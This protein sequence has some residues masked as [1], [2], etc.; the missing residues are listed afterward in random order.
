MQPKKSYWQTFTTPQ[1]VQIIT[2]LEGCKASGKTAMI[3]SDTGTCKTYSVDK[4]CAK[5]PENTYRI[6]ISDVYKLKDLIDEI[7]DLVGVSREYGRYAISNKRTLD[8]IV[9]RLKAVQKAGGNPIVII[10]EGENMTVSLLKTIKALYDLLKDHCA[11]V[12]IGTPRLV[13]RMLNRS[14]TG[15]IGKNRNALPELYRRFKAYHKTITP[16]NK[17]RD[18]KPFFDKYVADKGLRKLLCT[19]C[20][21]YGEL[22]DYLEPA[23]REA[24]E[25]GTALTEDTFRIMYNLPKY[26]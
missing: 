24:D 13:N 26:N 22:N 16:V 2:T 4:F 5:H 8:R 18:F 9:A 7:A 15:G 6:T 14:D 3:I 23:L 19:L 25:K 10:D 21:N 17:E 12:L 11:I 20:E 1:F